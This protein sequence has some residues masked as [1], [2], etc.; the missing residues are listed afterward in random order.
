MKYGFIGCGN[1]GGALLNS[2]KKYTAFKYMGKDAGILVADSD[3]ARCESLSTEPGVKIGTNEEVIENC[4]RIFLGV[5]PQTLPGLLNSLRPLL[6]QKKPLLISMAAGV[7]ISTIHTYSGHC[8]PVIRIMPNMPVR[9]GKGLILYCCD[10]E[11]DQ[12]T[13]D[14]WLGDMRFAGT[15]DALPEDKIDAACA[16]S[17]CGP[18]FVFQM[19]EALADGAVACGLT[20]DKALQYAA[21]TLSGSAELMLESKTH[22][23][24]L[25]DRICSPGGSTIQGVRVLEK[26]GLR[27]ALMEAV[28]TAYEASKAL[29]KDK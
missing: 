10:E 7:S 11:V 28:I 3:P 21:A 26:A 2:L 25:K 8:C 14:E 18:A 1:M 6:A 27:G 24:E 29:G 4:D 9:V 22:P 13:V 12:A 16:L 23:G 19:I 15:L 20:R 5:K 17:G